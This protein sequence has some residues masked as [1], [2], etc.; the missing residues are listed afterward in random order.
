M[1]AVAT[2]RTCGTEPM[3]RARFCHEC[4]API[5]EADTPAEYKQVTVLFADVVHSM[6]IAAAVGAERLREIMA[7]LVDRA[8]TVVQRYGG[9]VDKFTGDGIMAVFGAPI[10]LEDHAIRA[11][12][13][14]LGL[15]EAA[16][17][18]A[19]DVRNLDRVDLRL[20]VGLNSGQVIAGEIGSG[21][22]GYTAI[23]EQVGIAQRMESAAAPDGVML[24]D[25]TAKLVGNAV[26]LGEPEWVDVKG[27]ITLPARRLLAVGEHQPH[28]RTESKL[29]GRS[30]E[31]TT[32]SG[33]LEEAVAGSGCIVNIVGPPGIGKSRL[34]RETVELAGAR[35]V[36]VYSTYCESHASDIPF[37]V[38]ARMLRAALGID[39]IGA[40]A[41]RAHLRDRFAGA[42]PEDL[43]LLD[44]QLAIRDS[45][46]QLPDI[47]ADARRRRLTAL[48]N[49]GAVE[50]REAAVYVIEDAH[51]I[52]EI[53]ESML[54]DFLAVVPQIP[55]L[56]LITY[57]PEY[58][59]ALSRIP[60]SQS[61]ALRPLND[62][63][64]LALTAELLGAD[65]VTGELPAQIAGRAAGN[66]FFVEEI[67]RDLAER[68]V[69][70]GEPGAYQRSGDGSDVDVPAT[71]QAT[72][73]ARI[74][75]LGASA[76][77]TLNAA[78]VIGARFDTELLATLIPD[79]DVAPLIEVELVSQ[80][81][82]APSAEYAFRHPLI[83]TVA[84][85]SQLKSVRAQIH[86]QLAA[87]IEARGSADENAAL[88]A[89]HLE[90]A[91]DLHA[92]FNWHMRA[93]TWSTFRD[94]GAARMSWRRARQVADRLPQDDGDLL[95]MRI[96]PRTLLCATAFRAGGSG[97]DTGFEELRELCTA[98]DDQ[99]SL[100]I[101]MAGL[102]TR[103]TMKAQ[104][105]EASQLADELVQLLAEIGDPTLTVALPYAAMIA[106]H[107]TAEMADV[108]R[109][110]QLVIDLAKGDPAKGNLIFES[111][112]TVATA[113]RG[114]AR[115][116]LGIAGWKD[117]FDQAMVAARAHTTDPG[118][119]A[120][121][122]WFEYVPA[123]PN[124]ILLPD[125][126]IL[127]NTAEYLSVAEQSGDD[128]AV[129]L[130]QGIHGLVLAYQDGPE[131]ERGFELLAKV[132]E[133]TAD[134]RFALTNL[135]LIDIHI[136]REKARTGDIGGAIELAREVA[137]E[138]FNCGGCIWTALVVTVLV[139][140]LLQRG[141]AGDVDEA[142][143]AIAH[144]ASVPTDPGFVL[145]E[146]SLLRLRA[147]LARARGEEASYRDCR[148]RYRTMA[149]SLGFEGH[150]KWAAAMP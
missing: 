61:I 68:G 101:G 105:R 31:L 4:G 117:D 122:M 3:E 103:Q 42:D 2:C 29:V 125:A 46:M 135:P 15:Q 73:G 144:L 65:S 82:F 28:R 47:A 137:D 143:N 50:R 91:G 69:L 39:E 37:H 88:I 75:R 76:K 130:A 64:T 110:A 147:L 60:G 54:A 23:G 38:V 86:R 14:A 115:W 98:A 140:A 109:F 16:Q 133:R 43:L 131:R 111:P 113:M 128:L 6:Q 10:A 49:A 100:A 22:L 138:L 107:E 141:G 93:G 124:G 26:V 57:R 92:A 99:H 96:A 27:A 32:V 7:D 142:E 5:A 55:S 74:D 121:V 104:R 94:M 70:Q 129:D 52:D 118:T 78:A 87:A 17:R 95:S 71:L 41:A 106:K 126:T 72:I 59:G 132:R 89:E 9:T 116:C 90:A 85:E 84:Y 148:D 40:E 51:W 77:R 83:R 123:I 112:L 67:V 120:G 79:V 33:I 56:V 19:I 134:N 108:L 36:P 21:S 11:C 58:Q 127:R 139:E 114:L 8:V 18:L 62:E 1:T 63:H 66:P 13:A 97:A 44:D 34:V 119:F 146:I 145:H 149:T 81:R 150:M 45:T 24:S 136:A 102:L 30:W 53:S 25:S 35:G 12:L 20:R 48:I 80:V